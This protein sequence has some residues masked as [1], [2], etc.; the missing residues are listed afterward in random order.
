MGVNIKRT[1][2]TSRLLLLHQKS[3]QLTSRV[4]TVAAVP[5]IGLGFA[6]LFSGNFKTTL[7]IKK[8]ILQVSSSLLLTS[9]TSRVK[10]C[11]AVVSICSDRGK[12]ERSA[13]ER[14]STD[15]FVNLATH[16]RHHHQGHISDQS[17][18]FKCVATCTSNFNGSV[19]VNT[20][21]TW[22]YTPLITPICPIRTFTSSAFDADKMSND[23][24]D[25]RKPYRHDSDIF[26]IKDLVSRDPITQFDCWFQEACKQPDIKEPNAI[27]LATASRS[28]KPSVRMVLLKGFC[29][30]GFKI[31]TN[32]DSRKGK[33]LEE[34]PLCSVCI[35]W[36]PLNRSVRIEGKVIRLSQ[37]ESCKYFNARPR[38]SQL[39]AIVSNQSTI[40]PNREYLMNKFSEL[41]KK[42]ENESIIPKPDFW[43]GYL[44]EPDVIEFWQGQTTRLHDRLRFR[45]KGPNEV[46]NPEFTHE[47]EDGWVIERLSP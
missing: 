6:A 9:A 20:A 4:S 25:M 26:D 16:Y 30:E 23:I 33:E 24:E 11:S 41:E 46:F 22:V 44:I 42:Y 17:V 39:G 27:A 14:H 43:G 3:P 1:F 12:A 15:F 47:G 10:N 37:E 36:E 38:S 8:S 45:K 13:G 31:F 7:G 40:I 28:G 29:K 19:W 5:S 2:I 34:N 32:F 21:S 35:H 18:T